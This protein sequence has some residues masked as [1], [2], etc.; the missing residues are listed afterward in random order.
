MHYQ[1]DRH[2][3]VSSLQGG[4]QLTKQLS[5]AGQFSVEVGKK[6]QQLGLGAS[7]QYRW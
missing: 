6:E 5:L 1:R 7:L 2:A 4:Y 3:F